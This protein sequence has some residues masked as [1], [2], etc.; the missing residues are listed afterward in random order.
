MISAIVPPYQMQSVPCVPAIAKNNL[1]VKYPVVF[2][3]RHIID[4][5]YVHPI[6]KLTTPSGGTSSVS[7]TCCCVFLFH[8][9]IGH[10]I[11]DR[12]APTALK[13]IVPATNYFQTH[14]YRTVF[15]E[16]M[17]SRATQNSHLRSRTARSAPSEL[18]Y[19]HIELGGRLRTSILLADTTKR[20]ASGLVANDT[21]QM[22][23]F[24]PSVS[25][26]ALIV[27]ALFE[28]HG[29]LQL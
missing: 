19:L 12:G 27:Q 1:S 11:L 16:S 20:C 3:A 29:I 22:Q 9:S 26:L 14:R 7:A 21:D 28:S 5:D 6:R 17:V 25:N 18:H 23:G 24:H 10:S 4:R 2:D 8:F 13:I 15:R